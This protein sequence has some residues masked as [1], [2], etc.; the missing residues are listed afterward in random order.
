[1]W[2]IWIIFVCVFDAW[3]YLS[4]EVIWLTFA[5]LYLASKF[6]NNRSDKHYVVQDRHGNRYVVQDRYLRK[7]YEDRRMK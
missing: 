7:H 6:G 3:E 2:L 1:M 5:I 4:P